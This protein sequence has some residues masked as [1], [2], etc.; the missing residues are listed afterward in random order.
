MAAM[1]S[2]GNIWLLRHDGGS[3]GNWVRIANV[4]SFNGPNMETGFNDST[5]FDSV[6]GRREYRPSLTDPGTLDMT[7]NYKPGAQTWDVLRA[8]QRAKARHSFRLVACDADEGTRE[9]E[10]FEAF[11]QNIGRSAEVD[12]FMEGNISLRITGDTDEDADAYPTISVVVSPDALT[13]GGSPTVATWTIALS[14]ADGKDTEVGLAWTGGAANP[15]DYTLSD[16]D[17][18]LVIPAGET[19]ATITLTCV[20]DA[21]VESAETVILT[22]TPEIDGVALTATPGGALTD[23]LTITSEDV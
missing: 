23:T 6:G 3:P 15:G 17:A 12:G 10:E 20:D 5:D 7:V 11:V 4:K 21:G 8:Q 16:N 19:Q 9:A 22:I 14:H 2:Y 1:E 13:E 18:S